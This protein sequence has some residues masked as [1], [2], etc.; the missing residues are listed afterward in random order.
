M[1]NIFILDKI[2]KVLR[3]NSGN[4]VTV[5]ERNFKEIAEISH[6]RIK[7]LSLC[8]NSPSFG[9]FTNLKRL[10]L[11]YFHMKTLNFNL[12]SNLNLVE[13]NLSDNQIHHIEIGTF[14]DQINLKKLNLSFNCIHEIKPGMLSDLISLE[15]L[16]LSHNKLLCINESL[17][18]KL[19]QLK[20]L[21]LSYN[22]IFEIKNSNFND[23]ANLRE[24]SL[25]DNNAVFDSC[26]FLV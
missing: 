20:N 22:L 21:N 25:E 26:S 10:N 11:N 18:N 4:L 2:Q 5:N 12:L 7:S 13:L 1:D 19:I 14:S 3:E 23:L 6:E 9:R 24:L 15:E 8:T 16:N 17:F